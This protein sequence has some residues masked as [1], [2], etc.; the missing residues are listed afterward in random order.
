MRERW[1][2]L[3]STDRAVLSSL[4]DMRGACQGGLLR[5][6]TWREWAPAYGPT[7]PLLIQLWIEYGPG[8]DEDREPLDAD[9]FGPDWPFDLIELGFLE[10]CDDGGSPGKT[11]RASDGFE[12]LYR[13]K[14]EDE[15]EELLFSQVERVEG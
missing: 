13:A 1:F 12:R 11:F 2:A 3:D 6:L 5:R 7:G 14:G 8:R 15:K 9:Y 10:R 4:F